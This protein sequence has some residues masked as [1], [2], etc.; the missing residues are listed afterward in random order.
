MSGRVFRIPHIHRKGSIR[1]YR[2]DAFEVFCIY[3]H[4]CMYCCFLFLFCTDVIS[5]Y[6]EYFDNPKNKLN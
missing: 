6:D 3:C 2:L 5:I 1:R 4:C